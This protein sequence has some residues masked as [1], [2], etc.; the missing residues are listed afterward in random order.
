MPSQNNKLFRRCVIITAYLH[1]FIKDCLQINEDD[2][3]ICADGGYDLAVAE[4]ICPHMVLGDFDS[5]HKNSPLHQLASNHEGEWDSENSLPKII[6]FP[7]EKDDT[8][9]MLALKHGVD[10]G[11]RNIIIIGGIGGR[12]DHTIANLHALSYFLDY[13]PSDG[14]K[15]TTTPSIWLLGQ[16]NKVTLIQSEELII[17]KQFPL[18]AGDFKLSLLSYTEQCTGISISGVQYPLKNATLTQSFPLGV[19]NEVLEGSVATISVKQ[20]KLLVIL[21]TD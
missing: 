9:T 8:D 7:V 10:L 20:G 1:G 13:T 16:K 11:F 15:E 4:N 18:R 3:I 5:A 6:K 17:H 2:Y 12:L 21:S 19:S 14:E